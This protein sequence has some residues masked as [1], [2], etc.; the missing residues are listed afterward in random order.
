M[1]AA[2]RFSGV[3]A[4]RST[5]I[6]RTVPVLIMG[7]T[8]LG[9][10]FQE[11]TSAVSMNV[12]GCRYPSR[13][14]YSVGSWVG[15]QVLEQGNEANAP[16]MRAQVR[17]IHPPMSPRELYQI[18]VELEAPANV[19]GVSAP[20]EDWQRALSGNGGTKMLM[21]TGTAP[22]K[23]PAPASPAAAAPAGPEYRNTGIAAFPAMPVDAPKTDAAKDANA[24][25][26]ERVV[27]SSDQLIAAVQGKLQQAAEK[28][29]QTAISAQVADAVR[30]ALTKIDDVC[31]ASVHQLEEHAAQRLETMMRSAREEFLSRMDARLVDDR[32][33]WAELQETQRARAEE[34]AKRIEGLAT[35]TH[36]NLTEAQKFVER[37]AAEIEPEV[38]V[39]VEQA[40]HRASEE[41]E[42]AATKVADRQL[43][44]LMEDKQMVTREASSQMAA[45]AAEMRA[46]LQT[47]A[48][49][50]IDEMRRQMEVQMELAV[51]DTTQKVGSSLAALESDNRA[52]C[53]ARRQSIESDV[54]RATAQSTEQFRTGIKAFLY[55]CLVAAVGAVDEHAKSTLDGLVKDQ[56]T[57]MREL[58]SVA[59]NADKAQIAAAAAA[60]ANPNAH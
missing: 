8:K 1:G 19:W 40:M 23:A 55:S 4:R 14:D 12:H 21:A 33:R 47:A 6:D 44:R 27:I 56:G 59:A 45:C 35:E 53:E 20:P 24:S 49:G 13:H 28:A 29:V 37:V 32:N 25:K 5:R 38:R 2:A 51:S 43:V 41:F 50:T 48:S 60:E 57:A 26:P 46:L 42:H 52:A 16:V 22:A 18:G 34:L 15:L 36:R 58:E 54:Q 30:Q 17:S 11:R 3:E 7:Q 9:L 10:S 31:K 39:R